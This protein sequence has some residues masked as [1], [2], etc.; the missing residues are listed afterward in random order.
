MLTLLISAFALAWFWLPSSSLTSS[1]FYALFVGAIIMDWW[2]GCLPEF[3]VK[4]I[5]DVIW[6]SLGSV[7]LLILLGVILGHIFLEQTGGAT[8]LNGRESK[9]KWVW[10][11]IR[12]IYRLMLS[13]WILSIPVFEIARSL[14]L[15]RLQS[16]FLS[17]S[18]ISI[19]RKTM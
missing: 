9:L 3:V 1:I 15:I 2:W 19:C 16:R 5:S 14:C 11:K 12:G 18:G 7:G 17:K 8:G 4:S 13:G 10:R 6:G